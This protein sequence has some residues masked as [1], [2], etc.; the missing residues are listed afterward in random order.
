MG[1]EIIVSYDG[2]PNDDDAL[3]LGQA[4][5]RG[6][7]TLALAYVRHARESDPRREELS[8]QDARRRLDGG[9]ERLGDPDLATHVVFS[10]STD[11]GLEELAVAEGAKVIVFG[12]DYRTTPGW[13]EPGNT[14]QR[15]LEGG[16]V[17]VAVAQA[18]LRDRLG[19]PIASI[20]VAPPDAPGPAADV[21][22]ELA[23]QLQATAVS[24]GSGA[25]L[26]VVASPPDGRAG[27][28]SLSGA[29][30]TAL[31]AAPGSV[32]VLPAGVSTLL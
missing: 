16:P 20:A 3:A 13:A 1:A 26:I 22:R 14:A 15:L 5:T 4:L 10:A 17:A 24:N 11:G 29:A 23:A 31:N 12:S 18:G 6:G 25:D 30:R 32:L 9:L 2:T 7:A 28:L 21:A 27:R 8:E 19:E